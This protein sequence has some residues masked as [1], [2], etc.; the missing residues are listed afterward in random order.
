MR[1]TMIDGRKET[2]VCHHLIKMIITEVEGLWAFFFAKLEDG[3]L[4]LISINIEMLFSL[5]ESKRTDLLH[6]SI[7]FSKGKVEIIDLVVIHFNIAD[8]CTTP[9]GISI[10]MNDFSLLTFSFFFFLYLTGWKFDPSLDI[11][12]LMKMLGWIQFFTPLALFCV[13][14]PPPSRPV[15]FE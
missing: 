15:V 10:R 12:F 3:N 4:M 7:D 8:H 5:K 9:R 1:V 6:S 13:F 11:R 2:D 14:F